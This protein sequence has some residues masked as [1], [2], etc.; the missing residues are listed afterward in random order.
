MQQGFTGA[1]AA[2]A[3]LA[4]HG[5]LRTFRHVHLPGMELHGFIV[6]KRHWRRLKDLTGRGTR[7]PSWLEI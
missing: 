3:A 1:L 5:G 4:R 2:Y 7:C 6:E